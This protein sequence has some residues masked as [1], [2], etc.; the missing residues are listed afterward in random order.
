M[1]LNLINR[2]NYP[3]CSNPNQNGQK[4]RD[5]LRFLNYV[6]IYIPWLNTAK[7]HMECKEVCELGPGTRRKKM[8]I[9]DKEIIDYLILIKKRIQLL[10][11]KKT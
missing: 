6:L 3:I 1:F 2:H 7:S 8:Y 10:T 4:K 9:R 5:K 11:S